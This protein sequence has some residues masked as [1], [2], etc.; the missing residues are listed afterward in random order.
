M[1][2]AR[3]ALSSIS[4]VL[5]PTVLLKSPGLKARSQLHRYLRLL[6]VVLAIS[7]CLLVIRSTALYGFSH[8]LI[9]YSLKTGNVA[10]A[11]KATE[12][13]PE[14]AEAYFAHAAVLSLTGATNESIRE[15]EKAV[16]LR[17]SEYALWLELGLLRDQAG[18]QHGAL[19]AFDAASARAPYYSKPRWQRGNL[20]LRSGQVEA[21]FKDLNAAATSDME[22]AP[23]LTDLAWGITRGDVGLSEQ[24][25]AI[26]TDEKRVAFATVLVRRGK[27]PEAL[28]QLK[29]VANLSDETRREFVKQLLARNAF[30]EA[31]AISDGNNINQS[32]SE[33][34]TR[35]LDGGFEAPLSFGKTGFGWVLP[36][37]PQSTSIYVNTTNP[38]SGS[39]NLVVEYRGEPVPGVLMSQLILVEPSR[40]YQINFASR[41]EKV[42]SG[43]LP[44]IVVDKASGGV[45]F[46]TSTP[47]P[48]GTTDWKVFSVSFTTPPDT[49]AVVVSLQREVCATSPCPI[50]GA[51]FFDS[52]SIQQLK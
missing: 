39:K 29:R 44:I 49:T 40:R 8:V 20:L 6:L 11:Q 41:S 34:L 19:E 5:P 45:R 3:F 27:A 21:A 15:L 42:V 48:S 33:N 28:E 16:A 30:K 7:A 24:L 31:F 46:A 9:V 1:E 36:Q 25:A 23:A 17:H 10:A 52:F 37:D 50:F 2:W 14:D 22:L 4:T 47:L 35:F 26:N 32:G 18:D 38:N 13:T 51:V 12:L 43:A